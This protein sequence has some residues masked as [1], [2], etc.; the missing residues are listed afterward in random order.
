MT[1]QMA[2]GG[3]TET[4]NSTRNA[5]IGAGVGAVAGGTYGYM[6]PLYSSF[7]EIAQEATKADKLDFMPK[8]LESAS[9]TA[10]TVG[11]T[12]KNAT[13]TLNDDLKAIDTLFKS[14]ESVNV[15]VALNTL[16][17]T[18]VSTNEEK[19]AAKVA[20]NIAKLADDKGIIG[21]FVNET[22]T[23]PK[24][25]PELAQEVLGDS[26]GTVEQVAAALDNLVGNDGKA[27]T[28]NITAATEKLRQCSIG[29]TLT[30]AA[31]DGK[32]TKDSVI[33][34]AKQ[35]AAEM[36]DAKTFTE[37]TKELFGKAGFGW[38]AAKWAGIGLVAAGAVAWVGTKI[39]GGKKEEVA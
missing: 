20:E 13:E 39:F 17:R 19:I 26:K 24:L 4:D 12:V 30:A 21:T 33:M 6:K 29:D 2:V 16:G 36:V 15:G 9:D 35:K 27:I 7:D 8:V 31:Q 28:D 22:M 10:K 38:K 32:V 34:A 18:A 23:Y 5:L 1:S 3:P 37:K 25:T 14:S 11:E